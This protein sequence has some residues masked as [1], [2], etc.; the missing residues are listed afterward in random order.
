MRK[1]AETGHLGI[2]RLLASVAERGMAEIVSQRQ[3]LRE[4]FVETE[5]AADRSRN[6]RHFEAVRQ[7]RPVVVALVINENLCLVSETAEGC[8][9]NYAVTVPLKRRPHRMLELRMEPPATFP[10][11]RRKRCETDRSDHALDPTPLR[12]PR[13][14]PRTKPKE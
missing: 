5:R 6:L 4:V 3:S 11:L 7:P 1:P 14:S 10:R 2:E 13:P 9:M 12:R 8:R